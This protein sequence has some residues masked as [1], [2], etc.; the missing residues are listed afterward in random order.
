H[1]VVPHF[2]HSASGEIHGGDYYSTVETAWVVAG[3]LWAAGFLK[4]PTLERL[5]TQLYE[6][7]DWRYWTAPELPGPDGLLRHGKDRQRSFLACSWDRLNGETAF[8]Y[9]LAAGASDQKTVPET[10][11]TTLQPFYGS[12]AGHRFNNAD[13]GLF[14]F[15]Y[16]LD[17]LDLDGW[18]PPCGLN[19]AA[20][21]R[22]ATR[23]NRAF[24]GEWADRFATYR[25]YSGASAGAGPGAPPEPDAYRCYAPARPLDGTAHLTATL[26]SVAHDPAAVLA[27]LHAARHDEQLAAWG[28]Y[29]FSNVNV[30]RGWVG[31]D[32]VGIDAGAAVL[33]VGN[34]LT[35]GPVPDHFP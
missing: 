15:Q 13:L 11:W 34:Y 21:A 5:A 9:V 19:L 3:A 28:R 6:R 12:V 20:E 24:C 22:L 18:Q 35:R 10:A 30:D 31:R 33:A 1:G 7:V 23:A 2:I 17:L 32:L 14:V 26:A 4:D 16:G 25:R 29:G 27:N 8:M